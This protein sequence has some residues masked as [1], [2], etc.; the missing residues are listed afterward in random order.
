MDGESQSWDI[1][2]TYSS[3]TEVRGWGKS[4]LGTL[5][6]MEWTCCLVRDET[7]TCRL[8]AR[9]TAWTGVELWWTAASLPGCSPGT[10]TTK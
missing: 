6:G 7:R 8:A 3:E 10:A 4:E 9:C 5:S 1:E 2:L